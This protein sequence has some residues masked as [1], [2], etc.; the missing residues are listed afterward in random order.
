MIRAEIQCFAEF[1]HIVT[2][3]R[4]YDMTCGNNVYVYADNKKP[5]MFIFTGHLLM[6]SLD[7]C[8]IVSTITFP[9]QIHEKE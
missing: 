1:A 2:V 5:E 4:Q 9:G 8:I 6:V 7:K 3:V